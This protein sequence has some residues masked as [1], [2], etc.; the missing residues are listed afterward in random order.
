[1]I[2][3]K[4]KQTKLCKHSVVYSTDKEAVHQ[5]SIYVPKTALIE[6]A[7]KE[8]AAGKQTRLSN[9]FLAEISVAMMIEA[10]G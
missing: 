10:E 6:L 7:V 5:M 9:G 3:L 2:K 1:M 8:N 4:L